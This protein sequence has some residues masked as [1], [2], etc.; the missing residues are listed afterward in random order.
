MAPGIA[1]SSECCPLSV[2]VWPPGL[3]SPLLSALPSLAGAAEPGWVFAG[4]TAETV[5]FRSEAETI[6][7]GGE[8]EISLI[9]AIYRGDDE[10]SE[11]PVH[12]GLGAARIRVDC[13]WLT[14]ASEEGGGFWDGDAPPISD[15]WQGPQEDE[16]PYPWSLKRLERPRPLMDELC[17]AKPPAASRYATLAKALAWADREMA[18]RGI[19]K[20]ADGPAPL[21]QRLQPRPPRD[22]SQGK[23]ADYFPATPGSTWRPVE[24][25]GTGGRSLYVDVNGVKRSGDTASFMAFEVIVDKVPYQSQAVLL[26]IDLDCKDNV[27]AINQTGGWSEMVTVYMSDEDPRG[28]FPVRPGGVMA[29]AQGQVCG[30]APE[31]GQDFPGIAEA[32]EDAVSLD[33]GAGGRRPRLQPGV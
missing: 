14:M 11:G 3:C 25:H 23:P 8:R 31:A 28:S 16:A 20:F 33:D 13:D 21:P 22:G 26:W 19:I 10:A 18:P 1:R 27:F 32:Y 17:A 29:S 15:A 7:P 24:R 4:Q 2:R 30:A 12:R 6:R 5:Y 9:W